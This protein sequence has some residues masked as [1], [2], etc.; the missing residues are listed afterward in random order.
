MSFWGLAQVLQTVFDKFEVAKHI[1][2]NKLVKGRALDNLEF[3]QWMKAYYDSALG[4]G[5]RQEAYDPELR[6]QQVRPAWPPAWPLG[7]LNPSRTCTAS[8]GGC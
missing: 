3:M 1:E 4:S 6:R 5:R 8:V 7:F 2:V